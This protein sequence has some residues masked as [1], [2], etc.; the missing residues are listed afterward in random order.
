METERNA[1]T[2][3]SLR[4]GRLLVFCSAFACLLFELII[5]R[6]ADFHLGYLNSYLALPITFLGLALGSLHA[7]F[8]PA[9]IE[10][11]RAS[12]ALIGLAAACAVTLLLIYV[13]FSRYTIFAVSD[14]RVWFTALPAKTC[15]FTIVFILP[16]YVFGRILT[17]CYHRWRSQ[18]GKIYAADFFGAALGCFLTPVLFHYLS[19]PEVTTLLLGAICL[20]LLLFFHRAW[21]RTCL[22]A[23]AAAGLLAGYYV[24]IDRLEHSMRYEYNN[25]DGTGPRTRE[26]ASRWNEFSRVQL[27]RFEFPD[28]KRNYYKIIHDNAR[29][30]VHV[31]PYVPGK[32]RRPAA[33]DAKELPFILGRNT[34]DIL[35][36][37]AGCGAEMVQFNE[38][39]SGKARITG[40]ELNPLCRDFA[41]EAPE[42]AGHRLA[43]FYALPNIDL[44][45]EEGRGFL[46]RDTRQYDFIYVGS[47]APTSLSVT[48]H[49]RKYLYTV[50]AFESYLAALKPGG[51]LVFDHQPLYQNIQTMRAAFARRGIPDFEQCVLLIGSS[52]GRYVK[53]SYDFAVAPGGFTAEEVERL[54]RFSPAARQ[55]VR[56]APFH[57]NPAKEPVVASVTSRPANARP[58]VTDDRPF[59]LEID[60]SNYHLWP[61][62]A[63]LSGDLFY[64]SWIKITTLIA[65][66]TLAAGFIV[67][68]ML[69]KSRRLPPSVLIYL[70]VT[71]FCYL[72]VEVIFIARLELYLQDLLVSMACVISVFLLTSG[73]GSMAYQHVAGRLGM[74][75]FP[76]VVS[77]LVCL[78]PGMLDFLMAHLHGLPLPGRVLAAAL[79]MAPTGA[80][81]GMF[82]PYAVN[83]LVLGN[84]E[85]AVPIT[86]GVSTL[87]SVIGATYAM[88]VMQHMGFNHMLYQAGVGYLA[89]GFFVVL[90]TLVSRKRVLA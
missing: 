42:L 49:T 41:V 62:K 35:V 19:L 48:G 55:Q 58:D 13:L 89:L 34:D 84:C 7:H 11:F 76:L 18:I 21:W 51:L 85:N 6:L 44:R 12:R 70:V 54:V 80:A 1:R 63:E 3:G 31:A 79:V 77:M 28:P 61:T 14:R 65:L 87:S 56:Y 23:G 43:E 73:A 17:T 30:N 90:Y 67:L 36:M 5:S 83:R 37:F 81:L 69:S 15:L 52:F 72:I 8:R 22:F 9:I 10:R 78:S 38:Y 29:S 26:I 50:E 4:S 2:E 39:T 40:V 88:T 82:Y 46:M 57:A 24:Q 71:G 66:T 86:Y 60:F 45:I 59:V 20:M 32:T 33:L 47:S 53:G 25:P 16:F 68:A 75:L 74:R 27:V 64:L